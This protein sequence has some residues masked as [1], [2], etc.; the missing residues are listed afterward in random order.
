LSENLKGDLNM[1]YEQRLQFGKV[2][3][4]GVNVSNQN[5]LNQNTSKLNVNNSQ[6]SILY[7]KNTNVNL[8][9]S[10]SNTNKDQIMSPNNQIN[11]TK[12]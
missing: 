4:K 3:K 1:S 6:N 7:G 11:R 8:N 10:Q 12:V 2:K 5:V 9:S